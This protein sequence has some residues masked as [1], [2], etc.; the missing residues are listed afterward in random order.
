MADGI[1]KRN[2]V[3]GIAEE[4]TEGTYVSP[5]AYVLPLDGFEVSPERELIER[6]IITPKIGN[7]KPRKG[8]KSATGSLP[9]E[10]KA[11]G[12]EGAVP[13]CGLLMESLLG[14]V[15]TI[16][17][18]TTTE[19]S[20]NTGSVLQIEDADIS[21]FQVGDFIIVKQSAGHHPCFVTAVDTS[22][23]T[24][25]VTIS[26][27]KASG[28][29][30]NSVVISKSKTYYPADS[31]H[32]SL[33]VSVYWADQIREAILGAKVTEMSI[34]GFTTGALASINFAL[35]GLDYTRI[36]GASSG[37]SYTSGLP[38]IILGACVAQ[39]GTALVVN[40][41][42]LAVSN[43]VVQKRNLCDAEGVVSQI[44]SRRTVTGSFDPYT[45]DTSVAQFTKFNANT[46]YSLIVF[47]YTPSSTAG[48][49]EMGS[50]VGIYLPNCITTAVPIGDADTL[51][52]D[53]IEF[54]ATTGDN[55]DTNE[56]FIGFV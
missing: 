34:E 54:Q 52:I 20:G 16:S 12:T 25:N 2:S 42:S 33:S 31:G 14:S 8:I 15:H 56:V 13:E 51:L 43:E 9:L 18:T 4:V 41:F 7:P 24:A 50:A 19:S 40:N 47:A 44:V 32:K 5:S 35:Q 3:I 49:I 28:S 46:S 53:Q 30:S 36:D 10:L 38:P 17:T 6:S 45:D 27:A 11:S 23:G 48:E 29:F 39:D 21:K 26:P 37:A 1:N 22:S 55:G